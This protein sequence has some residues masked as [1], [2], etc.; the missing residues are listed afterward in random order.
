MVSETIMVKQKHVADLLLLMFLC[1]SVASLVPLPTLL[2][3]T[4]NTG[5]KRIRRQGGQ[6]AGEHTPAKFTPSLASHSST[7][8]GVSSSSFVIPSA[9]TATAL[10]SF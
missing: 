3:P 5:T 4:H 2:S 6:E 7:Y 1:S 8:L 10:I 9:T